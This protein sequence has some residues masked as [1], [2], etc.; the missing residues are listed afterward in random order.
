[1]S[2]TNDNQLPNAASDKAVEDDIVAMLDQFMAKGGGHMNIDVNTLGDQLKKQ[3]KETKS[4][5]C[6]SKNMACQ[7]PTR[8]EGIDTDES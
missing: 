7:I 2:P 4:N 5:E 8:H 6:N 3:V 1:M